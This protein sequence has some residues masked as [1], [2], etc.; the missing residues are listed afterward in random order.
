MPA[1]AE[2]VEGV[3][4][5]GVGVE[6]IPALG[7]EGWFT[8]SVQIFPLTPAWL[9]RV[10]TSAYVFTMCQGLFTLSES[11]VVSRTQ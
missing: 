1:K 11:L 4:K 3:G 2:G 8:L 10:K 9:V 6:P 7:R 5:R